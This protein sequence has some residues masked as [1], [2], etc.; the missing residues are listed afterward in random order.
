[1][2]QETP[3]EMAIRIYPEYAISRRH[4]AVRRIRDTLE[5]GVQEAARAMR[6]ADILSDI[7]DAESL[8]DVKT[9]LRKIVKKD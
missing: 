6:T 3:L 9:I 7:D 5:C 1:M 2:P 4:M 8:D